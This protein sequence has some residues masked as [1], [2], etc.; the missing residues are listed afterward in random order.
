MKLLAYIRKFYLV[1]GPRKNSE[2]RPRA[3]VQEELWKD[4]NLLEDRHP[5]L[6]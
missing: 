2:Q 3:P 4:I 1:M 5:T 6:E